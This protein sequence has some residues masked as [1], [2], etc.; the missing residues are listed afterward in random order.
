MLSM[1]AGVTIRP[2]ALPGGLDR[3]DQRTVPGGPGTEDTGRGQVLHGRRPEMVRRLLDALMKAWR[4]L[5]KDSSAYRRARMSQMAA[6]D[7]NREYRG[8]DSAGRVPW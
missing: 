1:A 3:W 6:E 2:S 4:W 5:G 7:K 8:P